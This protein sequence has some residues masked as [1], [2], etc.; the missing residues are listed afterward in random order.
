MNKPIETAAVALAAFLLSTVPGLASDPASCTTETVA[1]R[2][3]PVCG[4]LVTTSSG[5]QAKAFLGIPFAESTAGPGR[6]KGPTPKEA[7]TATLPAVKAGVACPQSAPMT[8]NQSEDC[9]NLNVWKPAGATADAKLPV[10]VFIYGGAF[11]AGDAA[12]GL[13]DGANMA[14]NRDVILVSFN[15]RVGV[16]GFLATSELSGNYGFMD[17]Q[18]A[19][20]WVKDNIAAW[21]GDPAKVTIFGESAGAMS[22]GLHLFSAPASAP[23]FRA[24]IMESNFFGLPYKRLAQQVD[25]GN[26]FKQGL[27][28]VDLKCLQNTD[29]NDLLRAQAAF[30]PAMS[31]VFSGTSFYIPFGPAIDGTLLTRQPIDGAADGADTK[32]VLLGTNRNEGVLFVRSE[33]MST[34]GYASRVASLFGRSF[35]KVLSRYPRRDDGNNGSSWAAVQGQALVVCSTRHVAAKAKTAYLYA[36]NKEPSF[37]VWGGPACQRDGNV[38][39]GAELPFV[40]G[41]AD[42]IGGRFTADEAEVSSRVMG[43]WTNFAAHLDP[44]GPSPVAAAPRWPRFGEPAK[45]YLMLDAPTIAVQSDPYRDTCEFWDGIGYKII[46]PW[47]AR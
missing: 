30:T 13:Y 2:A 22:V 7:W 18:A 4:T 17:Q 27:G 11:V 24:A 23:L 45:D 39:H 37:A 25:V 9:L 42:K 32:P 38:C 26:I 21:G 19:L 29:V 10:I 44:N 33:Q 6:W 1:S 16:L 28:C 5:K 36:F 43:Y 47:P 34:A 35:E 41:N 14:A 15:Y 20:T 46:D 40:F 3:G 12:Y 31:N 8:P